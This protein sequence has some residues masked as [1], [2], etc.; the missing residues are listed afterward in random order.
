M[1]EV[2]LP[3]LAIG[4]DSA[5]EGGDERDEGRR[6]GRDL[7]SVAG[8][9]GASVLRLQDAP[10]FS[11]TPAHAEDRVL[12][13]QPLAGSLTSACGRQLAG[14]QGKAQLCLSENQLS[15]AKDGFRLT[16]EGSG[17]GAAFACAFR[18]RLRLLRGAKV[19]LRFVFPLQS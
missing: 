12:P 5:R 1:S 14:A 8:R 18:G 13:W 3:D 17:L 4:A 16:C 7:P 19:P 15:L 10:V 9:P 6:P 11:A 2:T